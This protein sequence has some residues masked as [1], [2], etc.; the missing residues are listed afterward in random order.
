MIRYLIQNCLSNKLCRFDQLVPKF[1]AEKKRIYE[2]LK[3]L[4][5]H[6]YSF[7]LLL[8]FNLL[9]YYYLLW[10]NSFFKNILQ[11]FLQLVPGEPEKG[12]WQDWCS[13]L[14]RKFCS[15]LYSINKNFLDISTNSSLPIS[16]IGA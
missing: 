11:I 10:N 13:N 5:L 8:S 4:F 7:F 9:A 14:C 6:L 3:C 15:L 12:L 1:A 2:F 16:I